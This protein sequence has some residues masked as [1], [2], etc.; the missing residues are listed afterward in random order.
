MIRFTNLN[1]FKRL[2]KELDQY[3]TRL[4]SL[5]SVSGKNQSIW[6]PL[7]SSSFSLGICS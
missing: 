5:L 4:E 7:L 3:N 2:D 1:I 6:K